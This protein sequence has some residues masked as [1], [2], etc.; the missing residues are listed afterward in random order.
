M[1]DTDATSVTAISNELGNPFSSEADKM[2]SIVNSDDLLKN[3]RSSADKNIL[4]YV[5]GFI[6]RSI[7]KESK[8]SECNDL[9]DS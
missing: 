3:C 4:F 7:S 8:C 9:C 2:L 5:A 1:S 6:A